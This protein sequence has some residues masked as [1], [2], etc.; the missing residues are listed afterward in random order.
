VERSQAGIDRAVGAA[1]QVGQPGL[2]HT[3]G[4]LADRVE[5][6]GLLACLAPVFEVGPRAG[7]TGRVAFGVLPNQH[8]PVGLLSGLAADPPVAWGRCGL[9]R[10]GTGEE[11]RSRLSAG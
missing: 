8:R 7:S 4:A 2:Q 6:P 5:V 1:E 3:P 9:P 10:P 11:D